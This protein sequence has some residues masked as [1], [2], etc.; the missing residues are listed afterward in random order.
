MEDNKITDEQ[1]DKMV[2]TVLS[3]EKMTKK[4]L[5]DFGY[6]VKEYNPEDLAYIVYAITQHGGLK[7]QVKVSKTIYMV[8]QIAKFSTQHSK[9]EDVGKFAMDILKECGVINYNE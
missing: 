6:E 7:D 4:M 9:F 1:L 2:K 8:D 5:K 3:D